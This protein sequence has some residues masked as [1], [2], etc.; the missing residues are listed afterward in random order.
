MD[1]FYNTGECE[2]LSDQQQGSHTCMRE[3]LQKYFSHPSLVILHY[4]SNPTQK[5]EMGRTAYMWELLIANDED[6]Q[7]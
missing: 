7:S 6:Q 2:H 1:N 5:T 3:T 4:F